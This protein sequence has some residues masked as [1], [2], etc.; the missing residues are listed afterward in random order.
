VRREA[1][2]VLRRNIAAILSPV[3]ENTQVRL[4]LTFSAACSI[5]PQ[6]LSVSTLSPLFYQQ[7]A[8]TG[9]LGRRTLF[10]ADIIDTIS[11]SLLSLRKII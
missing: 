2:D 7:C 4:F 6:F 5:F 11:V 3:T 9:F 10:L 8:V 1:S